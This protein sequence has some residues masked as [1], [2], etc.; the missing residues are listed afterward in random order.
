MPKKSNDYVEEVYGYYRANLGFIPP[1]VELL[2]RYNPDA[3]RGFLTIRKSVMKSPPEGALPSTFKEIIFV[4]LDC[5][6]S[7]SEGAEAHAKNFIKLG[8][9]LPELVEAIVIAS[10]VTGLEVLVNVGSKAIK[11]AEAAAKSSGK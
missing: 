10:Y 1:F 4:I 5:T 2:G 6:R 11:A 7:N 9:K 3:L 8:G